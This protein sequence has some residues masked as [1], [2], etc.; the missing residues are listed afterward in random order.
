MLGEGPLRSQADALI[1]RY[2]LDTVVSINFHPKPLSIVRSA[3][4]YVSL[5]ADDNFGSQALLEAMGAGC[6][7]IASD[8]GETSKI[9]T[10]EV[11]V[12]VP[13]TVE[14]VTRAI[15]LLV[16]SPE[17][18]RQFGVCATKIARTKY[19]A[20]RYASF[21]ESLYERAAQYHRTS[22]RS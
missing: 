1:K 21:L 20:D 8:V 13:L 9:V 7:V 16:G 10:E 15:E 12:R 14:S 6:A 17:R 2:S 4:V 22:D 3:A 5:Q 18:T 11:G 19:S